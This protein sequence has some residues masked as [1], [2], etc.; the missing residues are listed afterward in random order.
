M[1]TIWQGWCLAEAVS[2]RRESV[3]AVAAQV[4]EQVL[5]GRSLSDLMPSALESVVV[6]DRALLQEL[7]YGTLRWFLRLQGV[8]R[9]LLERPLKQK[10]RVVELLLPVGLYQLLYM[11]VPAHAAVAE[12]VEAARVLGRPW[13]AG[14]VN[15]VLRRFQR[16]H[17]TL[18]AEVDN[19]PEL[20]FAH[21]R[22]FVDAVRKAWPESWQA[23]LEAAN[24]KPPM[25]LR[26][27][28]SRVDRE[29]YGEQLRQAG[30]VTTPVAAVASAL[31]LERALE[32]DA[33]PG[34]AE[35][36]VSVQDAGAQLA[37]E[38]LDLQPGQRVLDA[39]AAP[40][41]KSGH[42]L[43]SAPE[44]ELT[45]VDLD[46]Q[47]LER[48]RQNLHRLKLQASLLV[49]DASAPAGEWAVP[50]YDRILLDVPC[51][52]TG[53]IR[54]HP[55]IKLLRRPDDIPSLVRRQAQIL[56]NI[57]P[58]LK[59]GGI[60]LYAT[61]SLLPQENEQQLERFLAQQRDARERPIAADW[62]HARTVGRQ[63]LPGEESMD[64]FY[65]AVLCK[66]EA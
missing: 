53:V 10:D 34:F 56:N 21:P 3:R 2:Y 31:V 35:G 40:G 23:I 55:D 63:T 29:A 64:G 18:L 50:H 54:R 62:G 36:L 41:G 43:E 49:G 59:P 22:W 9:R 25:T 58:L 7:C 33:L 11:R 32:V 44:V 13:A 30:I 48:V 6:R 28:R 4:V 24:A 66:G 38:L 15:G 61:C 57:W 8:T 47:R 37:A 39:C 1:P 19:D 51:S 46:G 17:E 52:A 20:R 5:T 27:N 60:L 26:V 42:I 12:T 14:L 65:Y 16:E 45:A